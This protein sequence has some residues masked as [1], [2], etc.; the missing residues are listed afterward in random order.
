MST[1][2]LTNRRARVH[3]LMM[4]AAQEN[5]A[6]KVAQANYILNQI[7]SRLFMITSFIQPRLRQIS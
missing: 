5:K 1:N 6:H 4:Q 3:K 2:Y 7:D